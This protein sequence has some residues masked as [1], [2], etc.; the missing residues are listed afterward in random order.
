[1]ETLIKHSNRKISQWRHLNVTQGVFQIIRDILGGVRLDTASNKLSFH[2]ETLFVVLREVKKSLAAILGSYRYSL[3]CA[4]TC[5]RQ[6]RFKNQWSKKRKL[7]HRKSRKRVTFY[8]NDPQQRTKHFQRRNPM[9]SKDSSRLRKKE[10]IQNQGNS[11][12]K[13]EIKYGQQHKN[14]NYF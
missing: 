14:L 13:L 6:I 4:F 2:F 11:N 5:S 3:Y 1:M 12:E 10:M 9:R 8:L 7:S